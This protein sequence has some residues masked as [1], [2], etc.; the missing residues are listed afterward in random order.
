LDFL[1]GFPEKNFH[2]RCDAAMATAGERREHTDDHVI[3]CGLG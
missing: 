3:G 1:L 2:L